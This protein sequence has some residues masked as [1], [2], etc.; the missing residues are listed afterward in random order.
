MDYFENMMKTILE[1]KYRWVAQS[2]KVNLTKDE[3]KALGKPSIPRPEIDLLVFDFANNRVIAV[4]VKSYL[5]SG[6]VRFDDI[7]REYE[8][9]YGNLKLLTCKPYRD[10]VFSRLRIQL[11]AAGHI[12]ES[13][14]FTIGLAAG[15]VYK[16]EEDKISEL[17]QRRGWVFWSPSEIKQ[18]VNNLAQRG[19][20]NNPYVM[21]A[22]VLTR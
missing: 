16:N 9:T 22:K 5:D 15:N 3:K 20:E 12:S 4:E 1:V 11:L 10:V 2:V 17:F 6:G 14:S 18:L 7:D 13:T 19:Y 21:T 8:T